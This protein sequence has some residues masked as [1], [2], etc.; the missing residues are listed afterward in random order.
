ML[1]GYVQDAFVAS[2]SMQGTPVLLIISI[3][4]R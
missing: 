4:I 2:R 3:N 1:K